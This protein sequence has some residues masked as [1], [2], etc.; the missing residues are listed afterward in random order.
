MIATMSQLPSKQ[1]ILGIDFARALAIYGMIVHHFV[2]VSSADPAHPEWI[3]WVLSFVDGRPAALFLMLA[4][5]G[6]SL[7]T[8]SVLESVDSQRLSH[9]QRGLIKRGL[10]LLAFGFL[11][12]VI[13][14]GDILRV[15][16]VSLL[17]AAF[18]INTTDRWIFYV[19]VFFFIAFFGLMF[20]FDYEQNWDWPTMTY[21]GLW[22]GTGSMRNLFFDG[23][24]AVFPWSGFLFFGMW[25]GRLNLREPAIIRRAVLFGLGTTLTAELISAVCLHWLLADPNLDARQHQ[26]LQALLGTA[27][28]PPLPLFLAAA[29]GLSLAIIGIS[30]DITEAWPRQSLVK[31]LV[32]TG[33]L[34]LTWYFAHI[35][36]GLGFLVLLNA[37]AALSTGVSAVAGTGFFVIA[38]VLS[39]V[40]R[41]HFQNGP[42]ESPFR[43]LSN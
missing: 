24:R 30:I 23:F 34:S 14:P 37:T 8:R 33:Q 21:R 10:L 41:K 1:R 9:E 29:G 26:E 32:S 18:L 43:W 12:L 38:V 3:A 27:S 17:L 36:I 13:W 15:Y 22:T 28:M 5:V 11:N 40:W 39:C 35:Y 6:I 19:A 2:I 4:G 7:R 16:G 20:A 25:L 42:L 31:S